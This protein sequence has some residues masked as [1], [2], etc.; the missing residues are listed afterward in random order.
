M[1]AL[2]RITG[3]AML[4]TWARVANVPAAWSHAAHRDSL[5]YS[6]TICHYITTVNRAAPSRLN[7]EKHVQGGAVFPLSFKA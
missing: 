3:A 2:W 5:T 7:D 1:H 4:L 6:L